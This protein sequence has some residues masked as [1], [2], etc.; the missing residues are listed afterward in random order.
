MPREDL[1]A[2]SPRMTL[3]KLAKV[4]GLSL[5]AVSM[6]LRNHPDIAPKTRTRVRA[7][8]RELGYHPDP[9]MASLMRHLRKGA[10][11]EYRETIGF[12]SSYANY[13][14]WK[15][16]PQ[17]DAYLGA[18]ARAEE[19]GYR[20]EIFHWGEPGMRPG[21]LSQLLVARGIRGLLISAS[22]PK[23]R[24]RLAW[25]NFAAASF[26]YSLESPHIHRITS[27]YYFAMVTALRHLKKEGCR[28]IG[29][30]L[31]A[32]DDAKVLGLWR[33][34]YSLFQESV[35]PDR[36]IPVNMTRHGHG[37][38]DG[39]LRQHRPDAIISSGCDFPIDYEAIY[40]RSAPGDIAYVNLNI[41]RADER[42]R[43]IDTASYE[44]GQL[45]VG[46]LV[47]MLQRNETGLP[48][49][50][51]T[52]SIHGKWVEDHD[53]WARRRGNLTPSFAS[54]FKKRSSTG[55]PHPSASLD[56]TATVDRLTADEWTR[57]NHLLPGQ[58][59]RVGAPASN[60]RLFVEA[61]LYRHR[62]QIVWRKLPVRFGD[63]RVIHAR[64]KRWE[65]SGLW[66]RILKA[67][68][69]EPKW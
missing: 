65:R 7:L 29:F 57:I 36:R 31:N 17:H 22:L 6:A 56:A 30:N 35:Q 50:P 32:A 2:D 66:L 47:T 13:D 54:Y 5:S 8:A 20:L 67:L 48:N 69:K 3:R 24:L 10:A 27:D 28:R 38:L 52:L 44:L 45:G 63:F 64:F 41:R 39:W 49:D 12:L 4:A 37:S 25:E 60:N 18:L 59:G 62:E 61:I 53:A 40:Q 14:E 15:T 16:F 11:N 21:R 58:A 23:T 43:G 1:P 9:K 68:G 51:Q 33:S 26:G 42:S 34:A 19:L 46:H 55:A